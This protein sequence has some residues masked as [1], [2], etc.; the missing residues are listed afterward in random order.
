[1]CASGAAAATAPEASQRGGLAPR[2]AAAL[3][4]SL[5]AAPPSL[6]VVGAA[7]RP[8]NLPTGLRAHGGFETLME[9]PPPS[10]A[11]RRQL[12]RRLLAELDTAAPVGAAAGVAQLE[13]DLVARTGGFTPG[14]LRA[15]LRA[16]A[17]RAALRCAGAGAGAADASGGVPCRDDFVRALQHAVPSARG[18]FGEPL[19][20][21]RWSDVGGYAAQRARLQRLVE[22]PQAQGGHSRRLGVEPPS[23][24]L[25]YGP[26]GNGK[27]L[28]VPAPIGS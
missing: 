17:T 22:W 1:M 2:V 9:L 10:T 16:A 20:L 12:I 11:Q 24:A 27:S 7:R 5:R 6:L 13:E 14:D 25:L 26:S 28:L 18:D 19:P 8:R 4:S 21:T 23:G 15:L 3:L